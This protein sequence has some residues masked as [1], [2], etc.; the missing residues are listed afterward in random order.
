MHEITR[1][2]I[3]TALHDPDENKSS[4]RNI[5]ECGYGI[6][7]QFIFNIEISISVIS[8]GISRG[9]LLHLMR[10]NLIV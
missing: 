7:D 1:N 3:F 9:I 8:R 4:V 6:F 2:I 10:T 5:P